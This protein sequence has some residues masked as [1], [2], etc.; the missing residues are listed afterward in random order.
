MPKLPGFIKRIASRNKAIQAALVAGKMVYHEGKNRL[1]EKPRKEIVLSGKERQVIR[2]IRRDGFH[3]IPGYYS[4][5]RC[6]TIREEIDRIFEVYPE[7]LWTGRAG[8]DTR[9]FGADRVS[10]QIRPFFQDEFINRIILSYEKCDSLQG[11]TMAGRLR[12]A[13][14]NAGSGEGWHRDITDKRQTKA[15]LYLSD[16]DE[17]LGPF[18]YL[19]GSHRPFAMVKDILRGRLG[20]YQ[21]RFEDSEIEALNAVVPGRLVTFTA[22]AGTLILADTRGIHRGMP[23]AN[24]QEQRYALTNYVWP[25]PIPGHIAALM[26]WEGRI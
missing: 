16:V 18:L 10:E 3:V 2:D 12:Y 25:G 13:P 22:P 11:C 20:F 23:I 6:R 19:K 26:A 1:S 24:T 9:L 17:S 4:P 14:G 5:E 8:A 7:K 15:I 21:E